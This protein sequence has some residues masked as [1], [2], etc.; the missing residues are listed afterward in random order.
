MTKFDIS[1]ASKAVAKA[2]KVASAKNLDCKVPCASA[3][4]DVWVIPTLAV[5][6]QEKETENTMYNDERSE[7]Q[8]AKDYLIKSLDQAIW[9][10]RVSEEEGFNLRGPKLK[11]FGDLRAAVKNGWVSVVDSKAN[12]D[13]P[14][15][16][17]FPFL[18]TIADPTKLPD[19]EGYDAAMKQMVLDAS[20]VKD[21][22]V[23]MGAEKGLEALNAFKAKVYH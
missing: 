21:Q 12:D 5:G 6:N 10:K 16:D 8:Q 11:T 20:D 17:A 19:H 4:P 14:L 13:A 2:S 22:I 9:Q 7:A 1:K 3:V 23:V 15:Y 18:L